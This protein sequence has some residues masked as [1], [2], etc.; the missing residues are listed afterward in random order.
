M[1]PHILIT[2]TGRTGTT[3][4]V[5]ILTDL[6]LDTG[7]APDAPIDEHA[8]AGLEHGVDEP[9]AP[10]VVKDLLGA[11][12]LRDKLA[13]GTVEIEHAIVPMR[14]LDVATASRIRVSDFGKKQRPGG[15]TGT[16]EPARQS[17]AL[18]KIL[19]E[20]M[21][22]FAEYEIPFTP[23]WFPRWALDPDYTY[24]QLGFLTPDRDAAEWRRAV[25]ARVDPSLIHETPLGLR[26]RAKARLL[27]RRNSKREL[28]RFHREVGK[29][30][31]AE[32]QRQERLD[33]ERARNPQ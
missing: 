2:G 20:L 11:H 8:R 18:M 28:D 30:L 23:L 10:R 31:Q 29:A 25:E 12:L 7:F 27:G 22:A 17:Q 32:R 6:G 19:Y 24:R 5:Q 3:V 26:E 13:S 33:E 1:P 14:E 15:L 21:A 9:D 16:T 4:L